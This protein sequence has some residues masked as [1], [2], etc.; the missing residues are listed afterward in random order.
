MTKEHEKKL[1]LVGTE[2]SHVVCSQSRVHGG[3]KCE[4]RLEK[5]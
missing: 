1:V 5:Q 2:E 4:I 3:L